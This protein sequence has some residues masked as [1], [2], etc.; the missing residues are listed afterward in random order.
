M[1]MP[2][3]SGSTREQAQREVTILETTFKNAKIGTGTHDKAA[4]GEL[5]QLHNEE[6]QTCY[7]AS[8]GANPKL[9]G[10]ITLNL[11]FDA[12]GAT[13]SVTAEPTASIADLAAVTDCVAERARQW[14][15]PRRGIAG[16]THIKMSY[17][18]SVEK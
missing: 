14:K 4:L 2:L 12:S 13:K 15:L 3:L 10:T 11:T 7:E 18:L 17:T 6:V 8:L 16:N 9:A 1:T 5:L